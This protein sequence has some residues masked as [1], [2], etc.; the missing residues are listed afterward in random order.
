MWHLVSREAGLATATA[1]AGASDRLGPP[2]GSLY[3][4]MVGCPA[5]CNDMSSKW[6]NAGSQSRLEQSRRSHRYNGRTSQTPA[7]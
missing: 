5:E 7:G 1:T 2:G 4:D 3:P 6:P